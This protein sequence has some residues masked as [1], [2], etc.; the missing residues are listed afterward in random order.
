MPLQH[1]CIRYC[2]KHIFTVTVALCGDSLI[3]WLSSKSCN[4]GA[5]QHFLNSSACLQAAASTLEELEQSKA[6]QAA[7]AADVKRILTQLKRLEENAEADLQRAANEVC[8]LFDAMDITH[9]HVMH[10]VFYQYRGCHMLF[11]YE[12]S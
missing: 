2:H 1:L 8:F 9:A 3:Q 4:G 5:K 11:C 12:Q 7:S 10:E 6:A